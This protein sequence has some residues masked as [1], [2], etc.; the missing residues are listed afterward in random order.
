MLPSLNV[1]CYD[2][3]PFKASLSPHISYMASSE[4]D[5]APPL[6][7]ALTLQVWSHGPHM[8]VTLTSPTRLSHHGCI[9]INQGQHYHIQCN[10]P[11]PSVLVYLK[12]SS[13][14]FSFKLKGDRGL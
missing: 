1:Q 5:G 13:N 4:P 8:G 10:Q 6:Y 3:S 7:V 2:T 11:R 12:T 9:S 14:D